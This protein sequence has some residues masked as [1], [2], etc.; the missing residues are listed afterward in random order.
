MTSTLVDN[1]RKQW[2]ARDAGAHCLTEMMFVD[3]AL[4]LGAGTN[5]TSVKR[6]S[7]TEEARLTE[8]L[9]LSSLLSAAYH[10]PIGRS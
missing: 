3:D 4:K 8:D 5:L 2:D 6:Q 9:R 1:L 7:S 10:R